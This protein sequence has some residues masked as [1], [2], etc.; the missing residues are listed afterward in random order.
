M[1]DTYRNTHLPSQLKLST[2]LRFLATGSYQKSVG[3]ESLSVMGQSTVAKVIA[4]CLNIFEEHFCHKWVSMCRTEEKENDV[5]EQFFNKCGIPGIVGCVDGTHVRI[6]APNANCRHLYYNRKGFY[7]INVMAICDHD[8][9]ITFV[10]ARHPGA[11]HDS[12]IWKTSAAEEQLR[13]AFNNG[14][15]NTW[16]LGDSGYPLQP[17]LMTPYRNPSDVVQRRYNDKHCKARNIIE[18]CFG[19]LKNRFRSIIGSRGLH[20]SAEKTT[21]IVNACCAIHN[22]CIF[23]KNYLSLTPIEA[24]DAI[25]PNDEDLVLEDLSTVAANI[26]TQI[27]NNL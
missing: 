22:I 13:L 21:Q 2:F 23:Y 17:F 27:A 24:E 16:I 3:N 11:N 12:F 6:K 5:K 25:E 1:K 10:D 15:S 26:R 4:E 19:V 9:V 18:R 8:M 7:S 14:K 20:Y